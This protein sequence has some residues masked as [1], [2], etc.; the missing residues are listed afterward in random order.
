[1]FNIEQNNLRFFVK[2]TNNRYMKGRYIN[3]TKINKGM[4]TQQN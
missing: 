2:K 3:K 1:M 4:I